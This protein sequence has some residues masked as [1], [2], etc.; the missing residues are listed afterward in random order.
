MG[1]SSFPQAIKAPAA[2]SLA[3]LAAIKATACHPGTG[4][5][6]RRT[7]SKGSTWERGLPASPSAQFFW[8]SYRRVAIA[9]HLDQR[10]NNSGSSAFRATCQSL[11]DPHPS[12]LN[13]RFP[14]LVM[15]GVA[16]NLL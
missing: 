3:E 1:H 8:E 16:S 13:R 14:F 7:E 11:Y 2:L 9:Q 6:T 12:I 15:Q 10:S 5:K 4:R